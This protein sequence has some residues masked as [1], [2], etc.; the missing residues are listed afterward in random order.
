MSRMID[1]LDAQAKAYLT[2]INTRSVQVEALNRLLTKSY[3]ADAREALKASGFTNSMLTSRQLHSL[4]VNQACTWLVDLLEGN[5]LPCPIAKNAGLNQAQA[6]AWFKSNGEAVANAIATK[7]AVKAKAKA[8]AKATKPEKTEEPESF[9]AQDVEAA[10]AEGIA[11]ARKECYAISAAD[12]SPD[13][14]LQLIDSLDRADRHRVLA[15][16]AAKYPSSTPT[17]KGKGASQATLPV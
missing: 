10:K 16:L 8:D 6:I 9:T 14:I 17:R 5:W 4:V 1:L 2:G 15:A 7:K 12:I 3:T 13:M 11:Q